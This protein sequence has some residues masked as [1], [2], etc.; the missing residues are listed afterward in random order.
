MADDARHR[1]TVRRLIPQAT[2]RQSLPDTNRRHGRR[3]RDP[4]VALSTVRVTCLR[5]A[6]FLEWTP[7]WRS[8]LA[9]VGWPDEALLVCLRLLS[10]L[11]WFEPICWPN[12]GCGIWVPGK[13]G[14]LNSI[15]RGERH[16]GVE[17]AVRL[18][19]TPWSR[20]VQRRSETAAGSGRP[21]RV[22]SPTGCAT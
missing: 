15:A 7:P 22:E 20:S 16:L 12:E 18:E 4:I 21:F 3:R 14:L 9:S 11:R 17:R 10:P 5:D 2:P 8:G 13:C 1:G 19:E 6:L